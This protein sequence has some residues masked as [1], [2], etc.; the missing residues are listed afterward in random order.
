VISLKAALYE[1]DN[2]DLKKKFTK[3]RMRE[4]LSE[5]KRDMTEGSKDKKRVRREKEDAMN[6]N[7]GGQSLRK[8]L[9]TKERENFLASSGVGSREHHETHF[10]RGGQLESFPTNTLE[11]ESH[12]MEIMRQKARRYEDIVTQRLD[13]DEE[14]ETHADELESGERRNTSVPPTYSVN[15]DQ[16]IYE[17]N[18]EWDKREVEGSSLLGEGPKSATRQQPWWHVSN[19]DEI[20]YQN[21][22]TGSRA[23]IDTPLLQIKPNSTINNDTHSADR[24]KELYVQRKWRRIELVRQAQLQDAE[25]IKRWGIG[26]DDERP[27]AADRDHSPMEAASEEDADFD[28]RRMAFG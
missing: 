11:N 15:F 9:E 12:R 14:R 4:E 19:G 1:R 17:R 8:M 22:E 18:L 13:L 16:K 23:S 21:A 7:R 20:H 28:R 10:V 25:E 2:A 6:E 27:E 26:E 5:A 24:I 3:K